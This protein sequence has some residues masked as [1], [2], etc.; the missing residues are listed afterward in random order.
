MC[1]TIILHYS[2][3]I[4]ASR[5]DLL[6]L[7]AGIFYHILGARLLASHICDLDQRHR[8]TSEFA[9]SIRAETPNDGLRRR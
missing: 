6:S 7:G 3:G 9:S 2:H 5:A 8:V 4:N 1:G